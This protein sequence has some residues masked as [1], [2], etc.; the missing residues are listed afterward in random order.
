MT[1]N[2]EEAFFPGGGFFVDPHL[3]KALPEKGAPVRRALERK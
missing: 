1:R 2:N 3:V